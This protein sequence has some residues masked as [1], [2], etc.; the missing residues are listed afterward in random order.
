MKLSISEY[1]K[2]NFISF[3]IS[4]LFSLACFSFMLTHNMVLIDEEFHLT[5]SSDPSIF[6]GASRFTN[7]LLAKIFWNGRIIPF[8]TDFFALI[9]WNVSAFIIYY[10]FYSKEHT[11]AQKTFAF[12]YF[13]TIP[14]SV[15]ESFAFSEQILEVACAM[16][17]TSCAFVLT[18][19]MCESNEKNKSAAAKI[20]TG[21]VI[22]ILLLTLA[23]GSYQALVCVYVTA[24]VAFCLKKR[25]DDEAFLRILIYGGG[26]CVI[27]VGLYELVNLIVLGVVNGGGYL[28]DNYIGWKDGDILRTAAL[29]IANV[30][31]VSLAIPVGDEKI[32]SGLPICVLT[33]LFSIFAISSAQRRNKASERLQILF[34]S[35]GLIFSP[36]CIYIAMGSYRTHGR[37]LPAL[38][39]AGMMEM[40]F[41]ISYFRGRVSHKV[42]LIICALMLVSNFIGMNLIYE[43]AYESYVEDSRIADE[44]IRRIKEFAAGDDDITVVFVGAYDRPVKISPVNVTLGASFFEWDGGD[45]QRLNAFFSHRGFEY[46][47][48]DGDEFF[49][50]L[51]LCFDMNMYPEVGSIKKEGDLIVVYFSPPE[52]KWFLSNGKYYDNFG[53]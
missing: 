12:S 9:L 52:Y 31:R 3:I 17:F 47:E 38:S 15:G 36:F 21:V 16:V 11:F 51:D 30:L 29:S 45:N 37:T 48:P 13:S 24:I 8:F 43:K 4:V 23:I 42:I 39:V 25:L 33:A 27:S 28:S 20:I 2:K 34:L 22:S 35:L 5:E 46:R 18:V 32:Y 1:I 7:Y 41:I 50:A 49:L 26:I 19:F 53:L 40:L 44:L 14:Y 6:L 10:P